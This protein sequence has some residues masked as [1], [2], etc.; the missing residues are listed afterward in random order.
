[1]PQWERERLLLPEAWRAAGIGAA[2]DLLQD[3]QAPHRP[4]APNSVATTREPPV[5]IL[6]SPGIP[7][8]A[9]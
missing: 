3:P 7:K 8:R 4:V 2:Q 9:R 6:T 5:R 1:M